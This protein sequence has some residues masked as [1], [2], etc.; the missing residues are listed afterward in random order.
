LP[1]EIK[2]E[3]KPPEGGDIGVN[4]EAVEELKPVEINELKWDSKTC[5]CQCQEVKKCEESDSWDT[6]SC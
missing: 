4:P 6:S 1:P 3:S 2:L 5:S